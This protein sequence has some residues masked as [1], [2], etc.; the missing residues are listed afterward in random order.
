MPEVVIITDSTANL[1]DNFIHQYNIKIVPL[2]VI[3]D[4]ESY[5]DGVDITPEDFYN[6]L[7]RSKSMP[8]TSQVTVGEF[9]QLFVEFQSQGKEILAILL[10]SGISGT[11]D[12][13]IQA[14]ESMPAAKI[15][16]IDTLST[17]MQLGFILLAGARCAQAG[18]SLDECK[19]AAEIARDNSGVVFAVDT[20]DFLHRGGRI[21]GGKRFLGT[22]LNI[23][24]ILTLYD[25]RVEALEQVR[26]RRRSLQRLV[27]I[28]AERARGKN[29]LRIGVSHAN[30]RKDA[31]E[32][33]ALASSQLDPVEKIIGDLSPVLGTHAGP[34]TLALSYQHD[35]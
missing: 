19:T 35:A 32:L 8:S 14:R 10:S 31:E 21:G 11:I 23:K 1:P 18:G 20:L 16:I 5:D 28:V 12:S 3:W 29:N 26:T 9:K 17:T 33:M 25:G 13:A 22:M 15:E 7:E 24:P 30:A 27:E 6:R 4:G 2:K 34:G